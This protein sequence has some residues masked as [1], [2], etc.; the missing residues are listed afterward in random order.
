MFQQ[1]LWASAGQFSKALAG[2]VS[3]LVLSSLL[4]PY[5]YGVYALA[6]VLSGLAEVVVGGDTADIIVQKPDLSPQHE[7]AVFSLLVGLGAIAVVLVFAGAHLLAS[8]MQTP[9]IEEIAVAI[10]TLPL[11][12]AL[13]AVPTQKLVRAMR[14]DQLARID[15]FSSFVSLGCG[16][17]LAIAGAGI[18]SLIALELIRRGLHLTL[19]FLV[20]GRL[21]TLRFTGQHVREV[22]GYSM[23][24]I[25]NAA[26]VF[27][28]R[29]LVPRLMIS[30]LLGTT[31]LGLYIVALRLIDQFK[32]LLCDSPASIVFP[33]ASRRRDDPDRLADLLRVVAKVTTWVAWPAFLGLI[34]IAPLAVSVMLGQDWSALAMIVQLLT[35]GALRA[36]ISSYASGVLRANDRLRTITLIQAAN[37]I[38]TI[39]AIWIGSQ[40]GIV[41]V[42]ALLALRQWLIWPIWSFQ[43]ASISGFKMLEQLQALVVGGAP[44]FAMMTCV[45]TVAWVVPQNNLLELILLVGVG[46]TTYP[47]AWSLQN[48]PTAIGLARASQAWLHGDLN[49]ARKQVMN[50]LGVVKE[51]LT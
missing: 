12:T 6:L 40:F 37:L 45:W 19:V 48:R 46:L 26:I 17:G 29:R 16:I 7:A 10:A 50:I 11:L 32:G 33:E 24:R 41:V 20:A 23:R 44:A 22:I 13:S 39:I 27:V 9:E 21:E 25:E 8:W 51:T 35:L 2:L 28:A 14:F 3:V 42:A 36:P 18:W 47:I 1:S 43:V 34:A 15:L 30:I 5:I 38:L 4:G 31:S 49:A